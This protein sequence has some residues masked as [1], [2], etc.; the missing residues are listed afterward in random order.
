MILSEN[1]LD[2]INE[3]I[4]KN[5]L[6][7]NSIITCTVEMEYIEDVTTQFDDILNTLEE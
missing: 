5:E 6:L 1:V 4:Q 7:K 2:N 3:K